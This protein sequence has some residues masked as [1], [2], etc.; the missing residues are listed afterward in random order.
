MKT[1][2]AVADDFHWA[3]LRRWTPNKGNIINKGSHELATAARDRMAYEARDNGYRKGNLS[4]LSASHRF[5]HGVRQVNFPVLSVPWCTNSS[6]SRGY[7]KV[8]T[9][10][11]RL[12]A[13]RMIVIKPKSEASRLNDNGDRAIHRERGDQVIAGNEINQMML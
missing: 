3:M 9:Q 6:K 12:I 13:R 7:F 2:T 11:S 8:S 10:R 1:L 4:V 5:F